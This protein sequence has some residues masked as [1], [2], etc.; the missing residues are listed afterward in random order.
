VVET[1]DRSLILEVKARNELEDPD[2]V[3]KAN[4]AAKWCKT[5][6]IHAEAAQNKKWTYALIPDD[7]ISGAATI[8]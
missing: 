7:Q 3:A 8:D 5:A 2:V 1:K 4:A 6:S